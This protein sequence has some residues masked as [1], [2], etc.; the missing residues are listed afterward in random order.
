MGLS[1]QG[2]GGGGF[3]L[4]A[5]YADVP[6]DRYGPLQHH[7]HFLASQGSIRESLPGHLLHG[8]APPG[9]PKNVKNDKNHGNAWAIIE[10]FCMLVLSRTSF[11]FSSILSPHCRCYMVGT[12][13]IVQ[14]D[15]QFKHVKWL[16]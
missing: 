14:S 15:T 9:E 11:T 12:E 8:S 3:S 4:Y 10:V 6:L 13:Y 16:K 5:V 2:P 1:N 7:L